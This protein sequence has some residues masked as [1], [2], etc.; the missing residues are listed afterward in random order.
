VVEKNDLICP[1]GTAD[2]RGETRIFVFDILVRFFDNSFKNYEIK[3]M[4]KSR[5]LLY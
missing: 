1:D 2:E 5:P 4:K 3:I